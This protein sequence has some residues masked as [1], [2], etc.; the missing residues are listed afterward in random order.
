MFK[1][2]DELMFKTSEDEINFW[3]Y[4]IW[5]NQKNYHYIQF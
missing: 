2:W 5:L 1:N 4:I 3:L